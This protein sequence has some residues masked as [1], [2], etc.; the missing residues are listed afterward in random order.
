MTQMGRSEQLRG[1]HRPRIVVAP[2]KF[3]GSLSAPEAAHA[4]ARGLESGAREVEVVTLPIADG[5]EGTVDAAASCGYDVVAREVRGPTGL[6]VRAR[7]AVRGTTAIVELAQSS[8]LNLLAADERAPLSASTYGFGELIGHAI[9]GGA[10]TVVLGLGGSATTDGGTGMLIAMGARLTDAGDVPLGGGGGDLLEVARADFSE[11][12]RRVAGITFILASD[13]TNPLLGVR[14]SAAVFGPQKGAAEDDVSLLDRALERFADVVGTD[15]GPDLRHAAGAG[16][17]GGVGFA[18]LSVLHARQSSGATAVLDLVQFD[19]AARHADLVVTG[20]GRLDVQSLAGK[21]P[22]EV[23]RRAT[24]SGT[25]TVVVAGEILLEPQQLR[26]AGFSRWFS[27]LDREPDLEQSMARA[28]ELLAGVGAEIANDL[29]ELTV[30]LGH[31]GLEG[32]GA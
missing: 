22:V 23:A 12:R 14:G 16:A 15:G 7:Y 31:G 4:L 1:R 27:L 6:G 24:G 2:D 3:R 8:G 32:Y 11:L 9:D 20:E 25:A 21:A 18:A 13:V 29:D 28:A 17:A 19:E 26:S 30:R 10:S 5:G